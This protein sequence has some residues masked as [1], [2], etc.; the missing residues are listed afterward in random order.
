MQLVWWSVE[1]KYN[2]TWC[3]AYLLYM[4][5]EERT[6]SG[7]NS[8]FSPSPT[9]LE[10]GSSLFSFWQVLNWTIPHENIYQIVNLFRTLA[11]IFF[12][13]A[14]GAAWKG[15]I[16]YSDWALASHFLFTKGQ[17]K[18][19]IMLDLYEMTISDHVSSEPVICGKTSGG[20]E[21]SVVRISLRNVLMFDVWNI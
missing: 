18:N 14:S 2:C 6:I 20:T 16:L 13:K 7:F 11:W 17:Q 4:Y 8:Q 9:S 5:R 12:T 1:L 10:P 15:E 19:K 3:L 21:S